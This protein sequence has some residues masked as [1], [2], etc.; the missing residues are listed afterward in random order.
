MNTQDIKGSNR[1]KFATPATL[2]QHHIGRSYDNTELR[3]LSKLGK[4]LTPQPDSSESASEF[5]DYMRII[6]GDKYVDLKRK[7]N[8]SPAPLPERT[9]EH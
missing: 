6:V 2:K 8:L 9:V 1:M 5:D 7:A 3:K 4:G